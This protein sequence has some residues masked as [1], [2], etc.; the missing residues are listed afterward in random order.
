MGRGIMLEF[1][2]DHSISL[3]ITMVILLSMSMAGITTTPL[4]M[5]I[6]KT[7]SNNKWWDSNNKWLCKT[8][9]SLNRDKC[10]KINNKLIMPKWC[11]NNRC[12]SNK[13]LCNRIKWTITQCNNKPWKLKR[14][15]FSLKRID[16]HLKRVK[17]QSSNNHR[18]TKYNKHHS[19]KLRC[20]NKLMFL[21]SNNS[22]LSSTST[23]EVTVE[24]VTKNLH[25][26]KGSMSIKSSII[27]K[28]FADVIWRISTMS[29][30]LNLIPLNQK[31][32]NSLLLQKSQHAHRGVL[33]EDREEEWL[34]GLITY[35]LALIK[36]V[37]HS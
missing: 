27:L 11:S 4:P 5:V 31:V 20:N 6:N 28:L 7:S 14:R 35:Q 10:N 32:V 36:M 17:L 22:K 18:T 15:S 13:F 33:L 16:L 9:N 19:N 29:S 24:M 25:K 2:V 3:I 23:K 12:S 37:H 8:N 26:W 34:L 30:T 21:S 1:N